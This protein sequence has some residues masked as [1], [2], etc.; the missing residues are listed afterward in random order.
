MSC[1]QTST[2]HQVNALNQKKCDFDD[3]P[4][5]IFNSPSRVFR[6]TR[7]PPDFG[8]LTFLGNHLRLSTRNSILVSSI[9][10]LPKNR[11]NQYNFVS[12]YTI[13]FNPSQPFSK[14]V[15]WFVCLKLCRALKLRKPA[16]SDGRRKPFRWSFCK[17]A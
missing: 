17:G 14:L 6:K 13:N 7:D 16:Q 10:H 1:N 3:F 2:I 8:F 9:D 12:V 15:R 5:D 4:I 11:V